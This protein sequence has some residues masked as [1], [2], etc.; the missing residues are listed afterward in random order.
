[1]AKF[2]FQGVYFSKSHTLA[3]KLVFK[4]IPKLQLQSHK[5]IASTA[6]IIG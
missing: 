5:H 6:V 4:M 3:D 2:L 1:M